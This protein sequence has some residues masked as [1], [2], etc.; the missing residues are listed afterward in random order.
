M[1]DRRTRFALALPPSTVPER[2]ISELVA[3]GARI[4]SLNPLRVTLED[5]FIEQV[6]VASEDRDVKRVAS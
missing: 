6:R 2:L 1:A 3:S 4:L 5:Y